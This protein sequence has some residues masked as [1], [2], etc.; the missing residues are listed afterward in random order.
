MPARAQ[1]PAPLVAACV[2]LGSL[3]ATVT[4]AQP[5]PVPDPKPEGRP[6]AEVPS[7]AKAELDAVPTKA[8]SGWAALPIAS[9]TPET[10]L[11]LGVFAT[12]FLRF[13]NES[14]DTRPSSLSAVGLYTL[15]EQLITELIPEAYWDEER[16]HV[17]SRLDYRR[18]PNRLWD[19]GASAPDSSEEA[20]TEHRIRW[21]AIV[22]HA[23]DG[24]LRIAGKLEAMHLTIKG[25][26]P[27]GLI[28]S[29][30]IPG[31]SGGRTIGLGP[32]L[33]WDSRDHLLTPHTGDYYEVGVMGFGS[34][35]GSE[36]AFFTLLM[37]LRKYLPVTET[38]TLALQLYSE[39]QSGEVPFHKLA[40][41]GGQEL[42][43]GYYEGRFR[44][45]ALLAF[46]V[47]HRFPLFWRISGVT[48]AALGHVAREPASLLLDPPKWS[49]GAGLRAMLNTDERLNL[50]AD[51]GVGDDTF[52]IYV[53][54]GEAF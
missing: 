14:A 10:S 32:A 37:D 16:W 29:G 18:Y 22:D 1:Q 51:F 49:A 27:G 47:E 43:R 34:A 7:D 50:R 15:R 13:G 19:I 8:R 23:L 3:I 4:A 11:G 21:Q 40:Q 35:I 31:A 39:L 41:L 30:S 44:E 33:I 5:E 46:Q 24:P 25:A 36:H 38:H 48:H 42:L 6:A 9:Y 17:W 54:I 12:H 52:G 2:L 28:A 20:Y 53:G 45:K 26:E